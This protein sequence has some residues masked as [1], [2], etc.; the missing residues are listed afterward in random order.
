[1]LTL[2]ARHKIARNRD[3]VEW[4]RLEKLNRL[5]LR[6]PSASPEVLVGYS[7]IRSSVSKC[8]YT[9]TSSD[10]NDEGVIGNYSFIRELCGEKAALLE[11]RYDTITSRAP[12]SSR[13]IVH[14]LNYSRMKNLPHN[15]ISPG[16]AMH[17]AEHGGE[18]I[19]IDVEERK[20]KGKRNRNA[21]VVKC[22]R[23][24]RGTEGWAKEW[25]GSFTLHT[26]E[27]YQERSSRFF[28]MI[29]LI[30]NQRGERFSWFH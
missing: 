14:R 3:R 9:R 17:Y 6:N 22:A 21:N 25:G 12:G 20:G 24:K 16:S 1:M 26:V 5:P 8:C 28:A 13:R 30:T 7:L 27:C 18:V 29:A 15:S 4:K 11:V 2:L 10:Y 19:S 23:A